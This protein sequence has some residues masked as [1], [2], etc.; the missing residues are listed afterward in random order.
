MGNLNRRSEAGIDRFQFFK[1]SV[2][3]NTLP[4][5]RSEKEDI[6]SCDAIP[7]ININTIKHGTDSHHIRVRAQRDH[8]PYLHGAVVVFAVNF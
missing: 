5:E 2:R 3:G 4:E 6:P 7:N 1:R 8:H